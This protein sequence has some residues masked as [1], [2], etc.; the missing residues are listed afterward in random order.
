LNKRFNNPS[1]KDIAREAGVAISTVSNVIN[2][3]GIVGTETE[4]KVLKALEKIQYRPNIIARGLRTRSTS[5]IAIIV[6]DIV[7]PY[8]SHVIKGME[9]VARK[10][11]YTLLIACTYYDIREEKKQIDVFLDQFVDGFVFL[12]GY[13]N[14]GV[15][16]RVYDRGI[17]LV[18]VDREI[19]DPDI[20]YVLIDNLEAMKKAVDYLCSFGHKK[21]G[22][23]TFRFEY[24]ST[25]RNRYLGYCKGLEENHIDYDPEIVIIDDYMKLNETEGTFEVVSKFLKKGALPTAF[26]CISDVNAFGLVKALKA[27]GIKIPQEVSVIGFDNISFSN[28]MEPP[29]TT[30]KQPKKLMGATAMNLLLD[31]VEKKKVENKNIKLPTVLLERDSVGPPPK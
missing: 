17:P 30:I 31:M 14:Q 1:I 28:F 12:G 10:R 29:L 11:G 15:V 16:R 21:I 20:P 9:E 6:Q 23:V 3:K 27:E 24:Q 4:K 5:T 13:D 7:N 2:K 26:A 19:D 18:S 25:S 22:Y 8:T